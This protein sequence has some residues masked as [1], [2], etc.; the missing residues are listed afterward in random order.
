M[1][2]WPRLRRV[3]R[4]SWPHRYTLAA[5]IALILLATTATLALPLG[6]KGLLDQALQGGRRGLLDQF[7]L[8]LLA[9]FLIRSLLAFVGQYLMRMTGER[10]IAELRL[11]LYRH[12]HGMD[13]AYHQR[14]RIGDLSSRLASDTDAIRAVATD[15]LVSLALNLFQLLG[16]MAVMLVLNW[17]L[18][19]IVLL[20][21]PFVTLVSKLSGPPLQRIARAVQER[22]AHCTAVAQ[23]GL[24]A[25]PVIQAFAR[26]EYEVRRYGDALRSLIETVR[27]SARAN[28]IFS[29]SITFLFAV[30]SVVLFWFGGREVLG[31][32]L[33]AGDLV[34]FMFYSQT[35]SQCISVLATNYASLRAA[36]GASERV[37]ELLDTRPAVAEA[38]GAS[39]LPAGEGRVCFERVS[40][41]HVPGHPVL[42]DLS[43]QIEPGETVA[44]VGPSGTGKTTLLHLIPRFFDPTEG[45]ILIDGTDVRNVQLR[46]LR[47]QIAIVS[48][49]V[50]VFGLSV[51]ENIRFG[52]LEASDAEIEAAA[53]AAYAHDFI[54]ALPEGY[55]TQIG[56]RGVLLSGGQRQRLSIARAVLKDARILILDEATS[57][58]DPLAEESIRE[59]LERL[60]A[61]RTTIR[62]THR[63]TGLRDVDRILVMDGGRIVEAGTEEDL[64][65]LGG[66]YCQFATG[67]GRLAAKA[68]EGGAA[69]TV[70]LPLVAAA[71]SAARVA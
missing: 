63:L 28:A 59:A 60:R 65:A 11:S 15:V 8:G 57:S 18:S 47:E 53:R 70:L 30:S 21:T 12:L 68:P 9:L 6:M 17:R 44:L 69:F 46:S 25:L 52:R 66:L 55:D 1:S 48:Q 64:L 7:A 23:E 34:A 40:F 56:E 4:L 33:T 22:F 20:V 54:T 2:L 62:V 58:V 61:G 35:I 14:Q 16:S 45:R 67:R 36:A 71:G 13:L 32:R 49:D 29:S 26:S 50:Y 41:A 51:R 19:L 42:R 31:G 10:L 39:P 27:R 43:I 24:S 38:P 3:W 37:F 5:S